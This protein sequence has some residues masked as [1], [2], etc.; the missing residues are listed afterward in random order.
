MEERG[1]RNGK[2]KSRRMRETFSRN[3]D[4]GSFRRKGKRQRFYAEQRIYHHMVHG[5]P[6]GAC[7][8]VKLQRKTGQMA[9]RRFAHN[10]RSF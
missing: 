5:T 10:S 4:S 9:V 3:G 8:S 7:G 1:M 6:Y 2:N